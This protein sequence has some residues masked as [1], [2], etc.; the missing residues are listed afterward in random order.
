MCC[1]EITFQELGF[2][3]N[4]AQKLFYWTIDNNF[5]REPLYFWKGRQV[6]ATFGTLAYALHQMIVENCDICWIGNNL[7]AVKYARA[8]F[9]K[10][11][12][13]LPPDMRSKLVRDNRY[14]I[15]LKSGASIDFVTEHMCGKC[16]R[17]DFVFMDEAAYFRNLQESICA[18]MPA[19]KQLI[20]TSTCTRKECDF[21]RL[22][23]ENILY[24]RKLPWYLGSSELQE[25]IPKYRINLSSA[26]FAA[27]LCCEI[28]DE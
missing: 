26:A 16:R 15:C 23:M 13:K 19:A 21:Y 25:Q 12:N 6:G 11:Y 18:M 22:F 5:N 1:K 3:P 24:T 14:E 8:E 20:I 28:L 2:E 17:Y 7:A 4:P 9:H 10:L 27:E